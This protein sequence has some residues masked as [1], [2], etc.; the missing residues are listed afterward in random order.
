MKYGQMA[1]ELA[2]KQLKN[3]LE[4]QHVNAQLID[5]DFLIDSQYGFLGATPDGMVICDCCDSALIEIKC[6]FKGIGLS[7]KKNR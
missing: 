2:K 4:E 6:P 7:V 1:E 3:L 5:T